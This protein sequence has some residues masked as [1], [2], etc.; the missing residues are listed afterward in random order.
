MIPVINSSIE[1]NPGKS[2]Y[3]IHV[4]KYMHQYTVKN[5]AI[6]FIYLILF[7]HIF[8]ESTHPNSKHLGNLNETY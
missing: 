3:A 5:L 7:R 4:G 2:L 6:L 8:S 1:P